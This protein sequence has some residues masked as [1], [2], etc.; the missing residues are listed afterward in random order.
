ME[1]SG[2]INK[3]YEIPTLVNQVHLPVQSGSDRILS[4]MK[5]GYTALEYKAIISKLKKGP[6]ISITSD[7]I[8]GFPGETEDDF[9]KTLDLVKHVKFDQSFCF[10][11][12]PRPGT[13]ATYLKDD[14]TE[15]EKKDRLARLQEILGNYSA[16][17]SREMLGSVQ[18][19]LINGRSKKSDLVFSGRTENNR[20]VNFSGEESLIGSMVNIK[21]TE[22]LPNSLRGELV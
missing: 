22:V 20:V 10:I 14:T 13:P 8:V 19:V 3:H 9:Q 1:F 6:S 15:V 4:K 16:H 18:E 5:R 21:I 17:Y 2:Q 11:Y 7:F 12:S